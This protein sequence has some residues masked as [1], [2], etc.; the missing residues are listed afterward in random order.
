MTGERF[1]EAQL[2]KW[3][4][5]PN[6]VGFACHLKDKFGDSGWISVI[7]C[8]QMENT[9]MIRNWVMSCRVFQRG[10]EEKIFSFLNDRFGS[11]I[12]GR[13]VNT[14]RNKYVSQLYAKLGVEISNE[15]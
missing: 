5:S 12:S 9:V 6:H 15:L 3:L 13:Y 8:E 4:Q 14:D 11:K 1:T 2:E 7:L 10:L